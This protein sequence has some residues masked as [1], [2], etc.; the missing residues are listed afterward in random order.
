MA[1]FARNFLV[2]PPLLLRL[3]YFGPLLLNLPCSAAR[4][5]QSS[6][7]IKLRLRSALIDQRHLWRLE[8]LVNRFGGRV[9]C[10]QSQENPHR[11]KVLQSLPLIQAHRLFRVR[12]WPFT[13]LILVPLC[14]EVA[15]EWRFPVESH[16]PCSD[17]GPAWTKQ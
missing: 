1:S 12:P 7:P 8:L 14:L 13:L 9:G 16:V 15:L 2:T 10:R 17:W 6:L 3:P 5:N 4:P 11:W